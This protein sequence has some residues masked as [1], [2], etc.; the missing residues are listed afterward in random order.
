MSSPAPVKSPPGARRNGKQAGS[1]QRS[2]CGSA[3][4]ESAGR[5]GVALA[6]PRPL[7]SK[8]ST[9]EA[10]G[11]EDGAGAKSL[12]RAGHLRRGL[13]AACARAQ[14]GHQREGE[15]SQCCQECAPGCTGPAAEHALQQQWMAWHARAVACQTG[16]RLAVPRTAGARGV[17]VGVGVRRVSSAGGC[18]TRGARPRGLLAVAGRRAPAETKVKDAE[19]PERKTWGDVSRRGPCGRA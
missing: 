3:G 2:G 10:R 19:S 15:P 16:P 5:P 7:S 6:A 13:C 1:R 11:E 14:S 18:R 9:D 17:G 8:K 4:S 12:R